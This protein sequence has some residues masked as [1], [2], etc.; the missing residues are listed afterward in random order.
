MNE[1]FLNS[2]N[3]IK[4]NYPTISELRDEEIEERKKKKTKKNKK[5]NKENNTNLQ[6]ELNNDFSQSNH[7]GRESTHFNTLNESVC[8]TLK[9]DLMRI[10]NKLSI[11]VVPFS[12]KEKEKELRHWDLWGPFLFCILLG[13]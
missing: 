5:K 11:V 13:L 12:S 7:R 4:D 6:N 3:E 9:R 2:G 10:W 1:N 8:T